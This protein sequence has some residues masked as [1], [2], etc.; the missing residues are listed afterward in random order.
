MWSVTTKFHPAILDRPK[1]FN[2]RDGATMWILCALNCP[3]NSFR[4]DWKTYSINNHPYPEVNGILADTLLNLPNTKKK[5]V[6]IHSTKE[7]LY[8]SYGAQKHLIFVTSTKS[9]SND[10]VNTFKCKSSTLGFYIF[11][12]NSWTKEK[13]HWVWVVAKDFDNCCVNIVVIWKT[14][15]LPHL[16]H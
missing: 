14:Q 16:L 12:M 8:G 13:V 4:G 1:F 6:L 15:R 7:P 2:S 9:W 3:A 5:E 10:T 11:A